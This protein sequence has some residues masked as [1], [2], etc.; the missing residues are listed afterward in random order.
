MAGRKG[1]PAEAGEAVHVGTGPVNDPLDEIGYGELAAHHHGEEAECGRPAV[2]ATGQKPHHDGQRNQYHRPTEL[3]KGPQ[4]VGGPG[5]GVTGG[6]P[7]GAQ[8]EM[9]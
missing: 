9:G 2:T 4:D 3:G 7:G 8:V 6:E 5:A 1:R